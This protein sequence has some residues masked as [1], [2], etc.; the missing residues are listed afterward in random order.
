MRVIAKIG[1]VAT[2]AGLIMSAGACSQPTVSA[3]PQAKPTPINV[4][5]VE[6][7]FDNQPDEGEDG[8][9]WSHNNSH[10]QMKITEIE[11]GLYSV[12]TGFVGEFTALPGATTP[13]ESD[14]PR[15]VFTSPVTG[16]VKNSMTITL[17]A[18]ADFATFNPEATLSPDTTEALGQLFGGSES[19][20]EWGPHYSFEYQ[21]KTP[22]QTYSGSYENGTTGNITG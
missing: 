5:T 2:A 10:Y 13:S 8:T 3:K 6:A 7:D 11:P 22:D 14:D 20:T 15:A 17:K 21:R 12:T 18:P 4:R 19:I 1:L 9:V 16:T